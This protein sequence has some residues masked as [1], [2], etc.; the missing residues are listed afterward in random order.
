M[1]IFHVLLILDEK[2]CL[3]THMSVKGTGCSQRM[4]VRSAGKR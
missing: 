1:L 3:V 4:V 2:A